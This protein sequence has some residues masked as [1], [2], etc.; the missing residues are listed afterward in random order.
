MIWGGGAVIPAGRTGDSLIEMMEHVQDTGGVG[1]E[2]ASAM[3]WQS[4]NRCGGG[5]SKID[6]L[7]SSHRGVAVS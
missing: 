6:A 2:K 1:R 3:Q 5:V 4:Q 7:L